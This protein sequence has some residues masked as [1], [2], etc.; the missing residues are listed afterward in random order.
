MGD[1]GNRSTGRF[2]VGRRGLTGSYSFIF[3]GFDLPCF[4]GMFC[5]EVKFPSVITHS[6]SCNES[7]VSSDLF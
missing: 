7:Q 3:D 4:T 6:T 1:R 5:V 2:G